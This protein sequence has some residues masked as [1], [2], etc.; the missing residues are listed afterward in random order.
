MLVRHPSLC[1]RWQ[2]VGRRNCVCESARK[3]GE[4]GF[5]LVEV[6]IASLV[7][8]VA[9]VSVMTMVL[10]ALTSRYASRVESAA[11][12]LS[13]QKIEELKSHSLDHTALSV[14]GNSLDASGGIDFTAGAA[15][16]ATSVA[17][18]VLNKARDTKLSFETRW[19]V[20][21]SGNRKIITVATRKTDTSPVHPQPV[22]LKVV[23]AP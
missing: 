11:L 21:T 7:F 18:L 5:T 3:P 15:P 19:N 8:T 2:N 20:T 16:E 4:K 6:L 13:Q 9:T 23:L 17:E 12:K 22:S 1:F 14:T 10:F